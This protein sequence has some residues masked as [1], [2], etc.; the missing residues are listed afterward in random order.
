M[1]IA[2]LVKGAIPALRYFSLINKKNFLFRDD[3]EDDFWG[4]EGRENERRAST[5]MSTNAWC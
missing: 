2:N 3:G 1:L 4:Q 5:C